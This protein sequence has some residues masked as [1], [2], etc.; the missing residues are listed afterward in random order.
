MDMYFKQLFAPFVGLNPAGVLSAAKIRFAPWR[1]NR[2]QHPQFKEVLMSM[3]NKLVA[4]VVGLNPAGAWSAAKM[5]A[6]LLTLT[7]MV[8]SFWVSPAVGAEKKM[9]KDPT[10]G[11]MVTAPEYGGRLTYATKVMQSNFDLYFGAV[12]PHSTNV[13]EKLGVGNWG[14]D[15]D[16]WDFQSGPMPLSAIKGGLA[17]SWEMPDDTAF[18]FHIRDGVRWHS[19]APMNGRLLTAQDVEYTFHRMLGLGS[20]FTEPTPLGMASDLLAVPIESITATDDSTI[21]MKLKEPSLSALRVILIDLFAYIMPPEVIKQHGDVQDWR[22]VAGTGPFM[23]TG[24]VE[25]SSY[26]NTRNPD[27]WGYDE[28]YPENRLPYLD[29]IRY[30][31]IT[32]EATLQAALITGKIDLRGPSGGHIGSIDTADTL[33]QTNPEIVLYKQW[34]RS[35]DAIA[36]NVRQPPFDDIRV[37]KAMQMALDL[38]TITNTF[39]KGEASATP[40]GLV[41]VK[42][43]F[44]PFEEWPE[45]VKQGYRYDPEGARQLLAEA[46]YPD[47]FKT[48]L[49][50][51]LWSDLGYVEIAVA[52]WAAIGV[53]VEIDVLDYGVYHE[54]LF[55]RTYE[56]MASAIAGTIYAPATLASWYHSDNQWNRPGSQWPEM[57]ALVEAFQAATTIEEQQRYLKEA[58]MYAMKNHWLIWGPKLPQWW[59][60]HPWVKGYSGEMTLGHTVEN[61][62]VLSRLWIDSALKKEM[63]H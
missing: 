50:Y 13:L 56:G 39:F 61:D 15:R 38:D 48:T 6:L 60:L 40:Q 8:A 52:Y 58:D 27:Y 14:I 5:Q 18:V 47:G 41:G 55:S 31:M 37:R 2:S 17:E 46:G 51:S 1:V 25:E 19:K 9:V 57:D 12:V 7:L 16:K 24:F 22:N 20:G 43:Y 49:N 4:S 35:N 42:G 29:E 34:F 26:T 44:I 23:L 11:E 21:V 36:P 3:I 10:T 54:R 63:G 28:K 62:L 30:L 59:A 32:E 45:A 33:R 53:D